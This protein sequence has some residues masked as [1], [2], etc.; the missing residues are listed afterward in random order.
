MTV[1]REVVE[2]GDGESTNDS[3]KRAVIIESVDVNLGPSEV[4]LPD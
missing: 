3:V 4:S 2:V 1:E